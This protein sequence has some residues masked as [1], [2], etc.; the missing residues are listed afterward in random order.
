[1]SF[2]FSFKRPFSRHLTIDQTISLAKR[3]NLVTDL[4]VSFSRAL[5]DKNLKM[6]VSL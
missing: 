5:V 3:E 1:M 2:I 6:L 4:F